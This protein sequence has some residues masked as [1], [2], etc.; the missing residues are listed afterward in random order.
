MFSALDESEM[1][2]VINA[3]DEMKTKVG[4]NVIAEGEK[5]DQLYVVEEG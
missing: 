4:E 3:M 5:G 1:E 2:V